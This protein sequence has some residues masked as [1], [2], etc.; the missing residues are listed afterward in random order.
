ME[1]RTSNEGRGKGITSLSEDRAAVSGSSTS[2][3]R[4]AASPP[5]EGSAE[6]LKIP[7]RI[8]L[9]CRNSGYSAY[10]SSRL[11]G[12]LDVAGGLQVATENRDGE[13]MRRDADV[14]VGFAMQGSGGIPRVAL[15]E[16][17]CFLR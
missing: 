11:L 7:L 14:G 8:G 5:E 15:A 2:T 10:G 1:E 4:A 6:V 12:D 3:C 17:A 16:I 13:G 9:Q